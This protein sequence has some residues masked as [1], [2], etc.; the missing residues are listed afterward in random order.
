MKEKMNKAKVW[1]KENKETIK[2][3]AI[4]AVSIGVCGYLGYKYLSDLNERT[5][6][7][8]LVMEKVSVTEV[9][10]NLSPRSDRMSIVDNIEFISGPGYTCG[11]GTVVTEYIANNVRVSDCGAFGEALKKLNPDEFKD[12]T[13]ITNLFNATTA[14]YKILEEVINDDSNN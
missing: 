3:V 9:A 12:D 11:D 8:T 7:A 14:Q 2:N 5:K 4:S 10:Q 13:V 6:N 1:A